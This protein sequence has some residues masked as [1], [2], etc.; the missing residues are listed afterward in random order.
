MNMRPPLSFRTQRLIGRKPVIEDAPVIFEL[1]ASDANVT[2]FMGWLPHQSL[3]ETQAFIRWAISS[4]EQGRYVPYVLCMAENGDLVGMIQIDMNPTPQS[5]GGS[6]QASFGYVIAPRY[7]RRGFASEA[8]SYLVDWSLAQPEIH[9]AWAYCD[10]EN[11][12]SEGVMLKAGMQ[13]EGILRRYAVRPAFG[14]V[15]R[16]SIVCSKVK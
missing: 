4:F 16:D 8:L 15:P 6:F 7:K 5:R 10:P 9:R 12:A 1:Y 13:R 14:S 3:D 11:P 2:R